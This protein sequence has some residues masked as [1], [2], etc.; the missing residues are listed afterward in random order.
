MGAAFQPT[1]NQ[2]A[3]TVNSDQS[4][5]LNP[6]RAGDTGT[7]TPG[8]G[9]NP[10]TVTLNKVDQTEGVFEAPIQMPNRAKVVKVQASD[11]D[12]SGNNTTTSGTQR[13]R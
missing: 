12:S 9:G 4:L 13:L 10:D 7:V 2:T 5:S 1:D 8:T 3:F 6:T 11:A